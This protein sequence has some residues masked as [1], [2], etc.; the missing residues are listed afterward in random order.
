MAFKVPITMYIDLPDPRPLSNN[1]DLE[2]VWYNEIAEETTNGAGLNLGV[3]YQQ[4]NPRMNTQQGTQILATQQVSDLNTRMAQQQV[5][6]QYQQMPSRVSQPQ[7]QMQVGT[8][9]QTMMQPGTISVA[10]Q[11]NPNMPQQVAS[12]NDMINPIG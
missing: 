7:P 10:I 3:S 2:N 9:Q 6:N 5:Q 8:G 4:I 12:Q 11:Q 1:V